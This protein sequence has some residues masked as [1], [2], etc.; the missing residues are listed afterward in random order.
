M[1]SMDIHLGSIFS[2]TAISIDGSLFTRAC[3]DT[4]LCFSSAFLKI[5]DFSFILGKRAIDSS[6]NESD[7]LWR[8]PILRSLTFAQATFIG[9][10]QGF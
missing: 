5:G 3:V 2:R 9:H 10:K 8:V 7:F 1:G 4:S 6:E